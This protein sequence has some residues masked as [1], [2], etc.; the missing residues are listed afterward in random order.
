[1]KRTASSLLAALAACLAGGA[2]PALAQTALF[3]PGTNWTTIHTPHFRIYH[4]PELASK[5]R[6]VATIAED[7]HRQLVPFM[8]VEPAGL[9]EV[10]VTDQF[11]ELNS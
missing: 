9:T 11:D 10:V 7:A 3:E 8:G 1:M 2:A 4:T 6:E 5:A